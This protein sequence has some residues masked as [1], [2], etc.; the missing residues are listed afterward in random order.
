MKYLERIISEMLL[1]FSAKISML[2]GGFSDSLSD[3]YDR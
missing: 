1:D 2:A 3:K